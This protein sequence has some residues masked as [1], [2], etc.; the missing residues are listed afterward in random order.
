M[1]ALTALALYSMLSNESKIIGIDEPELHLHPP[2]QRGIGALLS[3]QVKQQV[4]ATNSP[5]VLAKFEPTHVV[6]MSPTR[7]VRQ[8]PHTAAAPAASSSRNGGRTHT[9]SRCPQPKF[10]SLKV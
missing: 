9:S 7:T 6:A 8:L 2:A 5:N 1:R 10:W 3:K 4:I